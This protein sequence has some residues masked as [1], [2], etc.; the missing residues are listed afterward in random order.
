VANIRVQQ[1][2][3]CL[4]ASKTFLDKT[5]IYSGDPRFMCF[6]RS[7]VWS[8]DDLVERARSY[9]MANNNATGQKTA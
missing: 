4:G 7:V 3:E 9:T 1:A 2:A 8:T 5:R 6:G